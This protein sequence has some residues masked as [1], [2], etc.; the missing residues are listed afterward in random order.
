MTR[1]TKGDRRELDVTQRYFV[2]NRLLTFSLTSLQATQRSPAFSVRSSFRTLRDRTTGAASLFSL[3]SNPDS[4]VL[5]IAPAKLFA[6][7][8]GDWTRTGWPA[9]MEGA[10][11]G[12]YIA[13]E[14]V[15]RSVGND[16]R[17]LFP[18]LVR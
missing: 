7:L 15:A 6:P 4:I 17:F 5:A 8:A 1:L 13:A 11:R 10:V 14:A 12:G 18:A 3:R 16:A 9:T 2:W